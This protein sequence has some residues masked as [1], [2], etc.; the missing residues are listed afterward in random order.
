[1][2]NGA[3]ACVPTAFVR[4]ECDAS[5]FLQLMLESVRLLSRVL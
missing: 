3:L 1:M 4:V 2:W 5:L